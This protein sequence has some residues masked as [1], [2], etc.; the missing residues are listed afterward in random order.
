MHCRTLRRRSVRFCEVGPL[1]YF[2]LLFGRPL[3]QNSRAGVRFGPRGFRVGVGMAAPS[4]GLPV[5]RLIPDADGIQCPVSSRHVRVLPEL[6]PWGGLG[7]GTVSRP[8]LAPRVDFF[9][10]W[11]FERT[12]RAG[13]HRGRRC[14]SHNGSGL[15]NLFS[16]ED[17]ASVIAVQQ[18]PGS[19]SA[20]PPDIRHRYA[21]VF[22]RNSRTP[23]AR[24][25]AICRLALLFR[26]E[27]T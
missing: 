13:S 23:E 15:Y 19:P 10:C 16:A 25:T 11:S 17:A 5:H 12:I 2:A 20:P 26:S 3:A 14:I 27:T 22:M 8:V 9:G 1:L 18:C 21:A 24:L 6:L 4:L 7:A